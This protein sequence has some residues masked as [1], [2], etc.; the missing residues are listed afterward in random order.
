[1]NANEQRINHAIKV[2][3]EAGINGGVVIWIY[4]AL[5][6]VG[7]Q[8]QMPLTGITRNATGLVFGPGVQES[9]GFG[10]HVVG[11]LIHFFFASCWGV[12]FALIWPWFRKRG[13]E[14]TLLALF[15]AVFA[16]IVMH[17][18]IAL[19][20]NTHPDYTDPV[21]IIGGF[22]SHIFFTVPLALIVKK[23]LAD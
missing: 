16:W 7:V 19:V 20:S 3:V 18:A 15:Y 9:L 10:A 22:M 2:G 5:V 23:R 12:L 4:E 1:M 8:H 21:V 6:W 14:A 11:T 17:A 13:V